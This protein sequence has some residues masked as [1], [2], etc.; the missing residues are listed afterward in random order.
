MAL[1]DIIEA[2][3]RET[4]AEIA[5]IEAAAR[6]RAAEIRQIGTTDA[7]TVERAEV[8]A[9]SADATVVRERIR[10]RA[11]RDAERELRSARQAVVA[12]LFDRVRSRLIALRGSAAYEAAFSQ[13]VAEARESLPEAD[14]VRVAPADEAL[15]R[16]LFGDDIRVVADLDTSCGARLEQA[17]GRAVDNTVEQR[18]T[19][20]D[21]NMRRLVLEMLPEL[22]VRPT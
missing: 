7:D 15:A 10:N 4:N 20:A 11:T 5:A 6:Q 9:R 17:D 19:R 3:E 14:I 16:R 12:E 22:G 18:L 2:I 8:S 1:E 13:L 21:A